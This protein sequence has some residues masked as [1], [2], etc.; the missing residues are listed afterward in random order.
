MVKLQQ[1][2]L[3]L[4]SLACLI[5]KM[6]T[7]RVAVGLGV[8]AA[9]L[10]TAWICLRGK[11]TPPYQDLFNIPVARVSKLYVYP[12]KSCHRIEV[13]AIKCR[14]RGLKYDR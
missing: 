6:D 13:E 8:C 7:D 9:G 12:V 5:Y 4:K 3:T 14:K 10:A 1:R 2:S 11:A